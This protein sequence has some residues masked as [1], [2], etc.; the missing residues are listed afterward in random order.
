VQARIVQ[1]L[2]AE[3]ASGEWDRK[4]GAWR[5]KPSFEGSLRGI[6]SRPPR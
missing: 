4:H 6:V 2:G 1:R 5:T 3:L